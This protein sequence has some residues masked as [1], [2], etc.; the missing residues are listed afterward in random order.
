MPDYF[1]AF[2]IPDDTAWLGGGLDKEVTRVASRKQLRRWTDEKGQVWQGMVHFNPRTMGW[3]AKDVL[4]D[5]AGRPVVEGAK[6]VDGELRDLDKNR[7]PWF[8]APEEAERRLE[9]RIAAE[10][11]AAKADAAQR[12]DALDAAAAEAEEMRKRISDNEF[13]ASKIDMTP[14]REAIRG[15][16]GVTV[17]GLPDGTAEVSA[18]Q[19]FAGSESDNSTRPVGEITM[20]SGDPTG[21]APDGWLFCKGQ[22]VSRTTYSDLYSVI[23]TQYGVG[24]GSTTFNVPDLQGKFAVGSNAADA[25]FD[26][27][28]ETGGAKTHTHAS[29]NASSIGSHDVGAALSNHTK[30][31]VAQA[32]ADHAV[33]GHTF[34]VDHSHDCDATSEITQFNCDTG[35]DFTG[36]AF[37][38][39]DPAITAEA[40]ASITWTSDPNPDADGDVALSGSTESHADSSGD[41]LSHSGTVSHSGTLSHDSPSHLPPYMALAFIIKV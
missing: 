28:G 16:S 10:N 27:W 21:S 35:T 36:Y 6:K 33:D 3:G 31:Q 37:T 9:A 1:T 26:Q 7:E 14:G 11:D 8:V 5:D 25:A 41:D 15:G 19:I 38:D 22:A 12:R 32:L 20:W 18:Q 39:N 4:R 29:H 13:A 2:G 40:G 24:D 17:T 30:A 34:N 23:E